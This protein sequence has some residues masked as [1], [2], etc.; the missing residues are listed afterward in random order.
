MTGDCEDEINWEDF[1]ED[2][3]V[4][5]YVKLNVKEVRE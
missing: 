4:T 5:E 2:G 1:V 3:D